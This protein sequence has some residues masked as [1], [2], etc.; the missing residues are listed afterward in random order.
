MKNHI[1]ADVIVVGSGAGGGAVALRLAERGLHVLL[2]ERGTFLPKEQDNWSVDA[3]FFKK[4]YTSTEEWLDREGRPFRPSM[5]Y[6]VGGNTK[7]FGCSMLRFRERDFDDLE[8]AEGL[9]PRWP[10]QYEDLLPYYEQAEALFGVHGD[11]TDDP[12]A[13]RRY[14]APYPFPPVPSEPLIA[15]VADRL[16]KAGLHPFSLPLSV[17]VREGGRCILCKTCDGFPCKVS[18]KNDAE[19]CLVQPALA[20]GRVEL[21]TGARAKRLILSADGKK[22]S[23]VEVLHEGKLRMLSAKTIVLSCG[24]VNSAA[25]LLGSASDGAPNGVSNSSGLVGRNYMCHNQTAMMSLSRHLNPTGFQKT[26]ALNDFYFGE[27]GFQYP[28][29]NIQLLGKLQSGMLAANVKFLP[30]SVGAALAG[31]SVDWFLQSEDLPDL[32]NRVVMDGNQIRLAWTQNNLKGHRRL[33]KRFSSILR[34][35]GFPVILTEAMVRHSTS[36]QCGTVRFGSDP[37]TSAIDPYCRSHDHNNLFVVDASF[38]PSSAAVNPAL[39][40]VAQ[41]LRVAD[42]IAAIDFQCHVS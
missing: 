32:D 24:A 21:M 42:H 14:G 36:H 22:I 25:L 26:L 13:P 4:L 11:D 1:A 15:S 31:R 28:M 18:G 10:I 30:R 39:T 9:S 41:A 38:F 29:G 27:P 17:D 12:T 19:S 35:I 37:A 2:L 6:N 34:G 8:H 33:V 23:A 3:V 5:F 20:T 40:I 7:F 16:H